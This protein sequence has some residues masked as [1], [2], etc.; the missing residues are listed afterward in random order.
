[1]PGTISLLGHSFPPALQRYGK[2]LTWPN[3]LPDNIT[4]VNNSWESYEHVNSFVTLS[5]I[6]LGHVEKKSYLRGGRAGT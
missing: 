6:K 5:W 2:S 3:Y 4:I 1:M